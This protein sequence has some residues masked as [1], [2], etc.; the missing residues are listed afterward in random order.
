MVGEIEIVHHSNCTHL[1]TA[2]DQESPSTNGQ[3][4]EEMFHLFPSKRMASADLSTALVDQ[5]RTADVDKPAPSDII[6]NWGNKESGTQDESPLPLFTYVNETI[7][8]SPV[9][10]HLINIYNKDMFTPQV[11]FLFFKLPL[12]SITTIFIWELLLLG[13]K[14][15]SDISILKT[16]LFNLWFGVYSRCEGA[17][18]SSGWEHVFSGEWKGNEVDGQHN[19]VRFY[20]L[21]KAGKINYHGYYSYDGYTWINELKKTGGFLIGTS[22]AFDF[23]LLT[24]CVLVH[25]GNN[26]CRFRL[27]NYSLAVTSYKQHCSSG[28]CLSTAYPTN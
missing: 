6:L 4:P 28:T 5:M 3:P 24:V 11:C 25:P 26:A 10:A 27:D 21:E 7:F 19:W 9:Y 13:V 18:G 2:I 20:L 14:E 16:Y 8:E 22:P 15:A 17:L 23:S 12:L 1:S